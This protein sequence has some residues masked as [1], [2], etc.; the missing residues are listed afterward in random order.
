MEFCWFLGSV[1]FVVR[2][3]GRFL[4]RHVCLWLQ[5]SQVSRVSSYKTLAH[6]L[7][8]GVAIAYYFRQSFENHSMNVGFY[9]CACV[10]SECLLP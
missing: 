2:F 3:L 4:R 7:T 5:R 10:I 6:L 1:T 8:F 9:K